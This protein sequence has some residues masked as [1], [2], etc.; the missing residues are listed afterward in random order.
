MLYV[1]RL[2]VGRVFITDTDDNVTEGIGYNTLYTYI[3]T[4]LL[5]VFQSISHLQIKDYIQIDIEVA[6][7]VQDSQ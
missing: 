5:K 6:H 7:I 1:N 3:S 4:G 2:E